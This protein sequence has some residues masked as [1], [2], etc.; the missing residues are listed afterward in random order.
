MFIIARYN[1][2]IIWLN[3]LKS[4]II[5]FIYQSRK[6]D[7]LKYVPNHGNEAPEYLAYIIFN[8]DYLPSSTLFLHAHI[9]I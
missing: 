7:L 8:Y 6:I 4:D 3:K 1:E 2:N 5:I 9:L